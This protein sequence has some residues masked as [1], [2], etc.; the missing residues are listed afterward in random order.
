MENN[1]H[2][3]YGETTRNGYLIVDFN[4]DRVQCDFHHFLNTK[5]DGDASFIGASWSSEHG[6]RDL[7]EATAS[8]DPRGR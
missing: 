8:L 1:L 6:S 5:D 2:V 3:R 4:Q 7:A